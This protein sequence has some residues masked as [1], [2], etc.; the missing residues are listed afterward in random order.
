MASAD[1]LPP[2][3]R[4]RRRPGMLLLAGFLGWYAVTVALGVRPYLDANNPDPFDVIPNLV[5]AAG[6]AV[7]A[8]WAFRRARG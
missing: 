4:K 2:P 8:A 7:W 6:L 1:E 3:P 5:V